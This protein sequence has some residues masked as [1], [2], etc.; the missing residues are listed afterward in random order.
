MPKSPILLN[1]SN[2]NF[3]W[4]TIINAKS[5]TLDIIEYISEMLVVPL[6]CSRNMSEV[7]AE[8]CL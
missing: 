2:L 8:D 5:E 7:E 3:L 1:V 6:G 4:A